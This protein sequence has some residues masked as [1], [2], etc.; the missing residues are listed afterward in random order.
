MTTSGEDVTGTGPAAAEPGGTGLAGTGVAGTRLDRWLDEGPRSWRDV[1]TVFLDVGQ[2][3][4]ASHVAGVIHEEIRIENVFVL[5]DGHGD[6]RDLKAALQHVAKVGPG[7]LPSAAVSLE[8]RLADMKST[9]SVSFLAPE[10]FR[11]RSADARANQFSFCVALYRAL[12][13][14]PPFD[15]DWAVSQAG[16]SRRTPLGS[17]HF[18]LLIQSFDR[19]TLINLAREVLSGNLRPPPE[20]TDV[21]VWLDQVLRRGL[22]TDPDERYPSLSHLL[23]EIEN[24]F[25]EPGPRTTSS[26]LPKIALAAAAA[27]L[28]LA[29]GILALSYSR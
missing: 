20:E 23:A 19:A 6:V 18:D 15:H 22:Q 9:E 28:V 26:R 11:G 8:Q 24:N 4:Q 17:I 1:V 27:L 21:P 14:Q 10:Q 29:A 16:E 12:Y 3:L 13:R 25:R 7:S 5:P 2:K